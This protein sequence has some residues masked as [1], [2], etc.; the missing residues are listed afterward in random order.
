MSARDERLLVAVPDPVM[1]LV[2]LDALRDRYDVV[3]MPTDE[4]PLRAAR[5]LK[6]AVVLLAIPLGRTQGAL[7]AARSLK[8]EANPPRVG[9]IDRPGRLS[10]P[11]GAI[12][13][14]VADGYLSGTADADAMR[15]FVADMRAGRR[16]IVKGAERGL[17]GRLLG[18]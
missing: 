8:T 2:A 18:R 9:L 1:R 14:G 3:P 5:R 6:P 16:P 13:G 10:D 7:R 11:E 4:D 15:A 17:I 12:A